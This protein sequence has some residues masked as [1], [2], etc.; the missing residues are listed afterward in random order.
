MIKSWLREISWLLRKMINPFYWN[1]LLKNEKRVVILFLIQ[2][3]I[4]I[5]LPISKIATQSLFIWG[6]FIYLPFSLP[7]Y[8]LIEGGCGSGAILCTPDL[9]SYIPAIIIGAFVY[10]WLCY[11]YLKKIDAK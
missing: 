3:V 5:V 6:I 1:K 9:E 11:L 2:I 4:F 7:L 8:Y 10:S